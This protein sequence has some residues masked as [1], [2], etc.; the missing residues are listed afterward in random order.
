MQ[1]MLKKINRR[2][3]LIRKEERV[4]CNNLK[5]KRIFLEEDNFDIMSI[6]KQAAKIQAFDHK[7]APVQEKEVDSSLSVD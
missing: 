7:R 6:L 4:V 2:S 5:K 3:K 1:V